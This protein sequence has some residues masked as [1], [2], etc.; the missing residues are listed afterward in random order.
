MNFD[1]EIFDSSICADGKL[2]GV[3]EQDAESGYFYLYDLEQPEGRKIIK[4]IRIHSGN[5]SITGDAVQIAWN[6]S[7]NTVGLFIGNKLRAAFSR[8][9]EQWRNDSLEDP[10]RIAP[11]WVLEAFISDRHH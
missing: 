7:N 9:G 11:P 8:Y 5:S 4:A 1:E 3:Y 10:I 2:A 6:D